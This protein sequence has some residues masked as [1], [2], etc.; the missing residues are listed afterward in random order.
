MVRRLELAGANHLVEREP[1]KMALAE[2]QPFDV[3]LEELR[4]DALKEGIGAGTLITALD[5]LAP[6]APSQLPLDRAL[7]RIEQEEPGARRDSE[8]RG[9]R[10]RARVVHVLPP[11]G[12]LPDCPAP[13]V[14]DHDGLRAE[15]VHEQ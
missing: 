6:I 8:L 7:G 5:G 9:H 15:P 12:H 2:T 14:P 10:A 4:Q 3:W 1:G 13:D 11:L